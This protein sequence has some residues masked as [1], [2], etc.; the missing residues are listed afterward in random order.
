MSE[1]EEFEHNVRKLWD[2][3]ELTALADSIETNGITEE[4]GVF[5]IKNG[6]RYIIADGHRRKKAIEMVYGPDYRIEVIVRKDFPDYTKEV[7]LELIKTGMFTSSLK[8]KLTNYEEM[9]SIEKYINYL[10]EL[11]PEKAPHLLT[12]KSVYTDFGFT[13]AKAMKVGKIMS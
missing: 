3:E 9:E 1:I 2:E 10:D 12:Q 11:H 13:K 5:H 4:I 8:T 7:E 6:D